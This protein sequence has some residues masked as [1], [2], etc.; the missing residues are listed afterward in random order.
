MTWQRMPLVMGKQSRKKQEKRKLQELPE[1]KQLLVWAEREQK[2]K[3]AL[4]F[5]DQRRADR[6]EYGAFLARKGQDLEEKWPGSVYFPSSFMAAMLDEGLRRLVRETAESDDGDVDTEQFAEAMGRV[7]QLAFSMT[8]LAGWRLGQG[9]YRFDPDL[10]MELGNSE[11]S[12]EMPAEVLR[13]LPEWCVYID[14]VVGIGHAKGPRLEGFFAFHDLCALPENPIQDGMVETLVFLPRM[15]GEDESGKRAGA[16]GAPFL[17]PLISGRSFAECVTA[18]RGDFRGIEDERLAAQFSELHT[19][20]AKLM[21]VMVL[22]LCSDE[23]DIQGVG[24]RP[25]RTIPSMKAADR[26]LRQDGVR[27]WDV[28][29]RVGS[30][31]RKA[32]ADFEAGSSSDSDGVG[33]KMRPH[34]RRAHFHGY[35]YGQRKGERRYKYKWLA[36]MLINV[37]EGASVIPTVHQVGK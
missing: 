9:V 27:C 23:P 34:M 14:Q 20:V 10:L 6:H 25:S 21:T 8:A 13:R 12:G 17:V 11:I 28:G 1:A 30:A 24:L 4:R 26:L 15:S 33:A 7:E 29:L 37:D 18:G 2:L 36:P 35:W 22:Y 19:Q 16:W 31:L 5:A 3:G 32:R